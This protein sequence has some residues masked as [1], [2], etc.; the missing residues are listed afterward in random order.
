MQ[1]DAVVA[2]GFPHFS[3]LTASP[4]E[5]PNVYSAVRGGSGNFG[6]ATSLLFRTHAIKMVYAVPREPAG[7]VRRHCHSRTIAEIVKLAWIRR[8]E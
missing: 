7:E 5:N 4:E 2:Q 3:L 6:V 1:H 8:L